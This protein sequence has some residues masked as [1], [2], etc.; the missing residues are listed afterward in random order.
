[1][2]FAICW[3]T[4]WGGGDYAAYQTHSTNR[5]NVKC[6]PQSPQPC[7]FPDSLSGQHLEPNRRSAVETRVLGWLERSPLETAFASRNEL[8]DFLKSQILCGGEA[9]IH[10][11]VCSCEGRECVPTVPSPPHAYIQTTWPCRATDRMAKSSEYFPVQPCYSYQRTFFI[12]GCQ[13][14]WILKLIDR[15]D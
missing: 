14:T 2:F 5:E 9:R 8:H 1:M 15:R 10:A 12:N 4:S 11:I 13:D 3:P 7:T 6:M